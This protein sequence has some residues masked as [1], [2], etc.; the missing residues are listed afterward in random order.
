MG[1]EEKER[2]IN[3]LDS[4]ST[5]DELWNKFTISLI[6][7]DNIF[8]ISSCEKALKRICDLEEVM[9]FTKL[10]D[11][12]KDIILRAKEICLNDLNEFKN[13]II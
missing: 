3:L 8:D 5:N 6:T 7:S 12:Q 9:D 4:I 11:S 1:V 10:S 13:K 2:L